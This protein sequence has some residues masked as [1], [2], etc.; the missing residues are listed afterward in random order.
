MNKYCEIILSQRFPKSL[1]VFDYEVPDAL[2]DDIR[3]GQL[4][5]IPFRSS[6]RDGVVIRLKETS[7]YARTIKQVATIIQPEPLLTDAQLK[8]AEWMAA[9]YFV[10]IGTVV[11]MML[12]PLPKKT[13]T[14]RSHFPSAQKPIR[15][16]SIDKITT[17]LFTN[18]E[19][20]LIW[21][22]RASQRNAFYS[23]LFSLNKPVLVIAPTIMDM[24]LIAG[25]VPEKYHT[26]TA[27]VHSKLN[28]NEQYE[29]YTGIREKKVRIIIGTKRALLSPIQAKTA[30]IID[31]E[32][33]GNH[34]QSDQNPRFDARLA[35][36]KLASYT[37]SP[38]AFLAYA[39][40]V[41]RYNRYR[42]SITRLSASAAPAISTIDM[43]EEYKKL[44]YSVFSE[45]CI[46]S[47]KKALDQKKKILL[48]INKRGT[49]SSVVCKDCG[50]IHTCET[51]SLPFVYH[52]KDDM[53][54]CHRCNKKSQVPPFC[55]HCSGTTFKFTGSGT[56]K[57]ERE[58]KKLW[59]QKKI[60]RF[61][62]DT[63][64]DKRINTND[65]IV[66]T[67]RVFNYLDWDAIGCV[68]I[69]S[70]D[71]FLHLPDYR[72]SERTFQLLQEIKA[73]SKA[74]IVIQ[75]YSPD[76]QAIRLAVQDVPDQFYSTELEDRKMLGYPPFKNLIKLIYQHADKKTCLRETERMLRILKTSPLEA[77]I[78]TPLQPYVRSKWRMY[79]IL[80]V[81]PDREHMLS[82]ILKHIP[83]T[84]IIDRDPETLL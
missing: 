15:D 43:R 62:K 58:I 32:E 23:S 74:L 24:Q 50:H 48:F 83:S 54:Y 46:E 38:I 3:V 73:R 31:Q 39:P 4:V 47:I 53:L 6:Q 5:S 56:Q 21:L 77:H 13:S 80:K 76:N 28:K 14:K 49:S 59:P 35:A 40:S 12:P 75:T 81:P 10:S 33:N 37:R 78:A 79:I 70:A 69:V 55:P 19:P 66:G 22:T 9:Y 30:I 17:R 84:W 20:S 64:P 71:T 2:A 61:D 45:L 44:H 82:P 41:A 65:I 16:T 7:P 60:Q 1:G 72:S 68:G 26:T 63:E 34:K 25:F 67:E 36:E 42:F 11:K 18:T 57:V 29:L 51:C 27:L 8:L 52:E